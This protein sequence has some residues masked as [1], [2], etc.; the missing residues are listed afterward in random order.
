MW[1]QEVGKYS[2]G[3]LSE[4]AAEVVDLSKTLESLSQSASFG[5]M[6]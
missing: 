4:L 6:E 3:Y 2:G 5:E 1:R